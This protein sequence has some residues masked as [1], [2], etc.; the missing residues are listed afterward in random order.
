ME[1]IGK[2]GDAGPAMFARGMNELTSP[3]RMEW[4]FGEGREGVFVQPT[5]AS[6]K[7]LVVGRGMP[8]WGMVVARL[9]L[10]IHSILLNDYTF[11]SLVSRYFGSNIPVGKCVNQA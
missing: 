6:E 11:S 2:L 7:V 10:R 8:W 3:S 9:N 4:D 1:R 5:S